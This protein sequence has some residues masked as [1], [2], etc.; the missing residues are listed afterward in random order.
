MRNTEAL[1]SAPK[2]PFVDPH[3]FGITAEP[4]PVDAGRTR[5]TFFILGVL[6][7]A[8]AV[9]L[10]VPNDLRPWV[11]LSGGVLFALG[12]ARPS[13]ESLEAMEQRRVEDLAR[14]ELAR[15]VSTFATVV[16]GLSTSQ[17]LSVDLKRV[18][19]KQHELGLTDDEVAPSQRRID[20]LARD[21]LARRVSTF[22]TAV[23]GLSTSQA[24]SVDLK[25]VLAQQ[26]EL[27]LTDDEVAPYQ[28]ERLKG[29][30][31]FLDFEASCGGSLIAIPA[32]DQIV[33][34][35]TCYFAAEAVHDKRGPNDPAG[36]L[37]LTNKRALF[38]STDGLTSA[39]WKQV[40]SVG[41]DGRT[42]RVQRRDRQNPYLFDFPT[43]V[44]AMKAE[45]IANRMLSAFAP[46]PPRDVWI[47][48]APRPSPE[49]STAPSSS[50]PAVRINRVELDDEHHCDLGT[51]QGFT[52]AVV[53][54]EYAQAEL[55]ALSAGRRLKCEEVQF[56]AAVTPEPAN[57]FDENAIRIDILN[58]AQLGY[59]SRDLAATYA[60]AMKS[61]TATGKQGVCRAR[62]IGG[63]TD[64]P[65]M[66]VLLDLL[67]PQALFAKVS[68]G[69]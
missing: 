11:F 53:G 26:H 21:E 29:L 59:L 63:T 19:A 28:L 9:V 41:L 51:G 62:L 6:T 3:R 64:E 55:S 5:K 18:S 35:D 22:A 56:V 68:P 60:G 46:L 30:D 49:Q 52:V 32:P 12:F 38:V 45:F 20:D 7:I 54:E 1:A 15:R 8:T 42:L 14:D 39:A 34:P 37:Y 69:G 65:A 43:Y 40:L 24:L 36:M 57:R 10:P 44:D 16:A 47:A 66:S 67:D 27:G 4:V 33:A 23:A 50:D 58:G 2:L 48:K 25:R 13:R 31:A 17:A 61:V